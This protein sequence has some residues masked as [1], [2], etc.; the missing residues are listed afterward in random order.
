MLPQIQN[1]KKLMMEEKFLTEQL[2]VNCDNWIE[3]CMTSLN[4]LDRKLPKEN[5][6]DDLAVLETRKVIRLGV[7]SGEL[8]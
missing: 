4:L 1:E 2:L 3:V 5:T 7:E 8:V 6:R